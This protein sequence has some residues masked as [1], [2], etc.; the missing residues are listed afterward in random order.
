MCTDQTCRASHLKFCYR[1][2]GCS[3]D[4]RWRFLA[5]QPPPPLTTG[6][7]PEAPVFVYSWLG[8]QPRL[9]LRGIIR[10]GVEPNHDERTRPHL[11]S[12][13]ALVVRRTC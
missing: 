7:V 13:R 2:R 5:K 1:T 10:D 6:V 8:H 11:Q 3:I 4:S 9:L 12:E